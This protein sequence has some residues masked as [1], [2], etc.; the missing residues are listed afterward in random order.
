MAEVYPDMRQLP[1][2]SPSA[3]RLRCALIAGLALASCV[4]MALVKPI[5]QN[6]AYHDFADR[7]GFL[8]V[9]NFMDVVSNAPF[10]IVGLAGLAWLAPRPA[11]VGTGKPFLSLSEHTAWLVFFAGAL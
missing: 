2:M 8:G 7:R 5:P 9:E 11:R 4:A 1:P 10:L 6:P 3:F